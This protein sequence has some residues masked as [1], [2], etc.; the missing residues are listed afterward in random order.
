MLKTSEIRQKIIEA[1]K[2]L[3]NRGLLP[4]TSGNLSMREPGSSEITITLSGKSKAALAELDFM[5]L[6]LCETDSAIL[7]R[8]SAETELH[9]QLY[10]FS[11]EINAVFHI[12]SVNSV[13]IS[14]LFPHEI[15]LQNY[16]LL[17][18]LSGNHTHQLTEIIPVFAN[19]QNID[20]LAKEVNQYMNNN[21]EIHAYLIEGHGL[22]AWGKSQAETLRHIEALE[23]LF[24]I[25]LKYIVLKGNNNDI[26]KTIY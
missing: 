23:T 10:R 5:D 15:K 12:H 14:K 1:A 26:S 4:A 6:A 17:K 2:I 16:E 18:A 8:C 11:N 22:Y 25:E 9:R 21:P 20:L 24:E 3:A 7:K 13:L 19:T